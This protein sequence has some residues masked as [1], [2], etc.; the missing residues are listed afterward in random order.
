[1]LEALTS[2][3]AASSSLRLLPARICSYMARII[4]ANLLSALSSDTSERTFFR[5][6]HAL[7]HAFGLVDVA[8]EARRGA[9][10]RYTPGVTPCASASVAEPIRRSAGAQLASRVAAHPLAG[11]LQR[12]VGEAVQQVGDVQ[13]DAVQ[14]RRR[15]S[16]AAPWRSRSSRSAR[17]SAPRAR[18]WT[19]RCTPGPSRSP[20]YAQVAWPM[21]WM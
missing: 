18:R 21:L 17:R 6:V 7:L 13:E 1:M 14:R 9:H 15:T 12:G 4:P 11:I 16:Y 20:R 5:R 2:S 10:A 3:A 19:D 8:L